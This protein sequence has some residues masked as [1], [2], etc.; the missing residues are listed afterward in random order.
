MPHIQDVGICTA[1]I[2][3]LQDDLDF[4]MLKLNANTEDWELL[5]RCKQM[6]MRISDLQDL[7]QYQELVYEKMLADFEEEFE[8]LAFSQ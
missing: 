1:D 8:A 7:I 5:D 3:A 2:E 6:I 4:K